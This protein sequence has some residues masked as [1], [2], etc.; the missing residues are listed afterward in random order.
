MIERTR[1]LG[2]LIEHASDAF[3]DRPALV[4][5][6]EII[7]YRALADRSRAAAGYLRG[8]GLVPGD[9]VALWLPNGS[10]FVELAFGC[11]LAGLVCVPLNTR[12]KR[13]DAADALRKS[14][15]R[16][17]FFTQEF[18]GIDYF[19]L[20]ESIIGAQSL[21]ELK[22]I[23]NIDEGS[24]GAIVSLARWHMGTVPEPRLPPVSGD[25]PVLIS[26]TSGT[27]SSPKGAVIGHCTLLHVAGAVGH[28]ME[29]TPEDRIISAMPFY[30]NGGFVP[31]L[32]TSLMTGCT[33]YTQPRFDPEYVLDCI[34]RHKCTLV[35]GVGTMFT[36]MIDSPAFARSDVR[37]VRAVRITG[38]ADQRRIAYEHFSKPMLYS[39]YGMSE[40]TAAVTITSP[41]DTMDEQL[42]TNG[43]P[44]PGA[45]IRI[46][47][48]EG[49]LLPPGELGEILIG[50][51]CCLMKGY[52]GDPE[53]T[54][55][56]LTPDGWMRSG[57]LGYMDR[58]GNLVLVGRIKDMY[59]SGGE[60][61]ACA[62]VEEF[63]RMHPAVLQAAI[64]GVPDARLGEVGFAFI[65]VRP[66]F[67]ATEQELRD[68]CRMNLANFKVP[69]FIKFRDGIPMTITGKV[70][71]HKLQDE[72]IAIANA[73]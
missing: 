43:K 42:N 46:V 36:M 66:G 27:T 61:V 5:Y 23:V 73:R 11:A 62:E 48:A 15:A 58:G 9:R 25:S 67:A 6:D 41:G 68:Y 59:R 45:S 32:L 24:A 8:S 30:H 2:E 16:A 38:P 18:L 31:T 57:D 54:A 34:G 14:G 70:E 44:L 7:T 26:F 40:T 65:E 21:A 60:N 63:L 50:G 33:L 10:A 53:A 52:F 72:A 51:S 19:A 1:S 12:L 49:H 13:V 4:I 29:I 55:K 28:R 39:L 56:V 64:L 47:G 37:S 35:G 20:V 3:G 71:K 17:L 69:R 22:L